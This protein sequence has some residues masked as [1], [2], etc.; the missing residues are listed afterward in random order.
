MNLLP[1]IDIKLLKQTIATHCPQN[2][3]TSNEIKRNA[4]GKVHF[5][6]YDLSCT[7]SVESP[8]KKIGLPDITPSHSSVTTH[9]ENLG[10]SLIVFEP[11]LINGTQI[12]YPGFPSLNVMPVAST[13]LTPIGLNC[14]GTPSK[15]PTMVLTMHP[16][17]ELPPIELLAENIIGKALFVNWPMMHEGRVVAL[18]D[19]AKEVRMTNGTVQVKEHSTIAAGRWIQDSESILKMYYTGNGLPGSGGIRINEIRIRLKL[20]PL[21]GM[22]TNLSNGSTKK[23]FGK[24]EADVPLQLALWQAPAPDPRFIE[25]GPLTLADR[26][27]VGCSVVLTKGKYRGCIG[28]VIDLVGLS[29]VGV[30]VL[31][32]PPEMP[33]GLAIARSVEETYLSSYDAARIL[34]MNPSVFGKVT[35]RLQFEQG[36]YDLGLNLKSAEG[37]CAVGYTRKKVEETKGKNRLKKEMDDVAWAAGDSVLV[38]GSRGVNDEEDDERIIWEYTPNAV[39]LIEEYR[40][41]FPQLFAA[42][43]QK[44]NERRYDANQVFGMNGEAWL[45]VVREWLDRHESAKLPRSPV[46]TE[47]MSYEAA[48]AVQK[49]ADV[50]SLVLRKRGYPKEILIKVPGSALYREGSTGATDVLLASDINNGEGPELGDRIVNLCADGVPF[51]L[52]G[53]VIGIHEAATSG[54]VEVV[55][56]EEFIGGTSLQGHCANFRGKLCHW[57]QLLK[58]APDNSKGLVDKLVPQDCIDVPINLDVDQIFSAPVAEAMPLTSSWDSQVDRSVE[59]YAH[60]RSSTQPAPMKSDDRKSNKS[61]MPARS[62]PSNISSG[63]S[64]QG[65][66]REAR[67]P[68]ENDQKSAGSTGFRLG[69]KSGLVRWRNMNKSKSTSIIRNG[70]SD[71]VIQVASQLKKMLNV[72]VESTTFDEN[73]L[74]SILGLTESAALNKPSKASV[75]TSN[76][77]D[78]LKAILGVTAKHAPD[79]PIQSAPVSAAEKLHLIMLGNQQ[80]RFF[81]PSTIS[82]HHQP[83]ASSPFNFAYVEEGKE[84]PVIGISHSTEQRINHPNFSTNGYDMQPTPLSQSFGDIGQ[85]TNVPV[86]SNAEFPALGSPVPT[87]KTAEVASTNNVSDTPSLLVPSA[88]KFRR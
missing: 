42:I 48:A 10:L 88:V 83:S 71:E 24:E 26:F 29:N 65:V 53:T 77:S 20:L 14:F 3:L 1:F 4:L 61:K 81:A 7:D 79:S 62:S 37:L 49:A 5:Y 84:L 39:R 11:K 70:N 57:S 75:D 9:E 82:S 85:S 45:P 51:G 6:R 68:T 25:R 2:K 63:R 76:I 21:Q 41:K 80:Q 44:P 16:M 15:Y 64:R 34:K 47:A 28:S 23:L 87:L 30:K 72:P 43:N 50:R 32:V 60:S 27:P 13:E 22:K 36:R 31:T 18:S 35:G 67:G 52:R 66:W 78:E 33:F 74:K 56:D 40:S 69:G 38:V 17:P 59:R 58:I 54:S 86:L 55:M 12:P 8:N 73:H 46:T 19:S